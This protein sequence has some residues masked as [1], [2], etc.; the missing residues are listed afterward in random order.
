LQAQASPDP[1]FGAV[2]AF[3]DPGSAA[4]L[5]LG[6]ERILFYWSQLQPY[7]PDGEWNVHHVPDNWISD[8]AAHG[9]QVVGLIEN[10]PAWATDG[11]PNIGVPR[12]L[13]LPID[14]PGNLW[15]AF[16]RQ[17]VR[18]YAGRI[19]HWII[20]NEPDIEPPDYGLQWEGSVADYYQLVKVAYLVAKQENPNAVI[21]LAGLTHHHDVVN[22]RTPYLQR[23][24]DEAKTDPSARENHFYF[25]VATLHIYF[26]TDSVYD[27]TQ[28]QYG[29]LRR[30]NLSQPI[31]INETNSPPS[32]DP[33]NPWLNPLFV[34]SLDQQADFMV[35]AFALGLAAGAQRIAAY[36]LIDFPAYEPGHEAYGLVRADATRRPAYDALKV[37]TTHF[38]DVRVAKLARTGATAVVT[39]D[40]GP[41]TTRIAWARAGADTSITLPA[42]APE[43]T[44][45]ALDGVTQTVAALNGQYRFTLPAAKCDDPNYGCRLGGR[46]IVLVE[47]APA[48]F[49]ASAVI[50]AGTAT[51]ISLPAITATPCPDC[52]PTPT[53]TA[54]PTATASPTATPIAPTVTSTSTPAPTATS[55]PQPTATAEATAIA[56]VVTPPAAAQAAVPPIAQGFQLESILG[57]LALGLAVEVGLIM[58]LLRWRSVR[59]RS[60]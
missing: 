32:I 34:T 50:Q 8:A 60:K 27:I 44:L 23:F 7:G 15:A 22:K 45:V 43:A 2:E 58:L 28:L 46:P 24:I 20:W 55:T 47:N 26:T 56:I 33:L 16:V 37:I 30:N 36:K 11:S 21:H 42:F 39:L 48:N 25:D 3:R 6:W 57:V 5:N 31:W 9:R 29:I 1:R 12:G 49:E 17:L 13:D 51:L 54:L 52:P 10:T 41:V 19:D 4:E 14:D 40:R 59:S 18:R 38:R 35:Q 53:V